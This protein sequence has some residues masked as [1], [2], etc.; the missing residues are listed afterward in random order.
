MSRA[1]I[2]GI[3]MLFLA[4]GV[5]A[6]EEFVIGP[7]DMLQITVWGSQDLSVHIPVRPDGRISVPLLGD[8]VADGLT[9]MQLKAQLDAGYRK[10]LK[11]P[12]VSVVVTAVNSYKV[13]IF[14]GGV[15]PAGVGAGPA[16]GA[17]ASSGSISLR[18]TT[19]LF[20]LLAQVGPLQGADL[21]NAYLQ[22]AGKKMPVNF[23]KLVYDG[24]SSQDIVL[25]R[26]DIIFIPPD[27]ENRIKVVGNVRTP[28]ILP[29]VKG[30]T[31]LDA[32]LGAGGFTEFASQN[33]VEVVRQ[34]GGGA[35][36]YEVRL[37]DVIRGGELDKNLSLR[38]GDIV[39]VK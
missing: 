10:Y 2:L 22:R 26:D 17:A 39:S 34:E 15:S 31:A 4:A 9:P 16:G 6:A 18:R 25:K 3:A 35:K 27:V 33:N 7:E 13:Y 8:I 30:M 19:T 24:D 36:L 32:V 21:K 37:R 11:D 12:N 1:I 38:P 28:G 29:Y 5:C 14:G 23:M 20:Q